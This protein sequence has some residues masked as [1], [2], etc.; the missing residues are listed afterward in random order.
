MSYQTKECPHYYDCPRGQLPA[1]NTVDKLCSSIYA[2]SNSSY[3]SSLCTKFGNAAHSHLLQDSATFQKGAWRYYLDQ[4]NQL[5]HD[6]RFIRYLRA[7]VVNRAATINLWTT[8][9]SSTS[10]LS[11]AK[12][13]N[14]KQPTKSLHLYTSSLAVYK[15]NPFPFIRLLEACR[16]HVAESKLLAQAS[17]PDDSFCFQVLTHVLILMRIFRVP[18][19][20]IAFRPRYKM[21]LLQSGAS[22]LTPLMDVISVQCTTAVHVPSLI[23]LVLFV[24]GEV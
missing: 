21:S 20:Y 8:L 16:K 5:V 11:S 13:K 2:H 24:V 12:M 19:W 22:L 6:D 7:P 14:R 17:L 18:R 1:G 9:F 23:S 3:A 15:F 10:F 4:T